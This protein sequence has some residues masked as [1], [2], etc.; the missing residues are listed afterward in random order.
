MSHAQDPH[1][2][3]DALVR[4]AM[5]MP[6]E[7]LCSEGSATPANQSRNVTYLFD[8]LPDALLQGFSRRPH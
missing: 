5:G 1:D 4:E 6:F 3:L 8:R 2:E 7:G